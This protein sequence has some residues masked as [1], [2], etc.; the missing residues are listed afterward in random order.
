MDAQWI[1]PR[2]NT[3]TALLLAL[4]HELVVNGWHDRAFLDRCCEGYPRFERYLMGTD[5]GT[6]KS[7]D[8]AAGICGVDASTI[9]ALAARLPG[10]RVLV[11]M[12][13]SLQ[14]A[15]HGEQPFWM[16]IALAAMLGQIGLPGGGFAFGHGSIH[17]VGN[18]RPAGAV[19]PE[20][21]MG[22]NPAARSSPVARAVEMLENPGGEYTF[23]GTTNHSPDIRMIYGA[24]GNPF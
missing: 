12:A 18:P 16:A 23:C 5:D 4:A 6:P 10:R 7:A 20:M 3:D 1:A 8:W 11:T 9:R 17:G 22:R 14:R 19:G 24:G 13:W 21:P 2:P 15:H